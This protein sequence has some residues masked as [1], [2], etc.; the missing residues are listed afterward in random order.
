[1]NDIINFDFNIDFNLKKDNLLLVYN[2]KDELLGCITAE[3]DCYYFQKDYTFDRYREYN[4]I[5][6]L[7]LRE[8]IYKGYIKMLKTN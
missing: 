1:M 8:E 6:E 7:L 3:D 2:N 4:S 5:V